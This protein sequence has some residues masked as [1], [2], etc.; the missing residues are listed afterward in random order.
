MD[1]RKSAVLRAVVEAYI[2]DAQPVGSGAIA[3][4]SGLDVSSATIRSE[5]ASL[6]TEGL[7][8]S[9]HTS[10]G[11]IPTEKGYRYFVDHIGGPGRLAPTETRRVRDFF[12]RAQGR[13]R[14]K[15]SEHLGAA[16][17]S[18]C[19]CG[20]DRRSGTRS[21]RDPV[22]AGCDARAWTSVARTGSIHR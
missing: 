9:P 16:I 4:G 6:E 3:S 10:S 2:D 21:G 1:D 13:D 11:R 5:M 14:R 20:R 18:H 8:T 12:Q 22:R 15:A 7:L 19:L 17:E